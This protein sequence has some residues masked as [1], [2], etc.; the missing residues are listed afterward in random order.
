M[1][2]QILEFI[3]NLDHVSFQELS[4]AIDGFSGDLPLPL[5][6]YENIIVWHGLS[7][8]AGKALIELLVANEI[9][10]HPMDSKFAAFAIFEGGEYPACPIITTLPSAKSVKSL[11]WFPMT[12]SCNPPDQ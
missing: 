1:K 12:L 10:A 9:F 3:K 7:P 8:E 5:P 11:H 4:R 6:G 2:N